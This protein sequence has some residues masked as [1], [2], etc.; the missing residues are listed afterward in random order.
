MNRKTDVIVIGTGLTGLTAALAASRFGASVRLIATG[1]G[2]LSISNGCIDLLGY[3]NGTLVEAPF[4]VMEN[5]PANHPYRLIGREA[6]GQAMDFLQVEL[7][8]ACPLNGAA[9]DEGRAVNTL[10]PTVAGTLK[11]SWLFPDEL[12]PR[13]LFSAKKVLVAGIK[14][15][16][17]CSPALVAAGLGRQSCLRGVDFQ[18]TT[19]PDPF[20]GVH[21]AVSP[22]DI[23]R[24]VSTDKGLGWLLTSLGRW[25]GK[26]DVILLPPVCGC[27]AGGTVIKHLRSELRCHVEEMLSVPPGVGGLRLRDAL[28]QALHE[29]QIDVI[30]N[31]PCVSA[32][33]FDGRCDSVTTAGPG[34]QMRH[35]AG[36]FIVATGGILGGG[37]TVTP[38][39]ARESIFGLPVAMPKDIL[40]RSGEKIFDAHPLSRMGVGVDA[41]LRALDA[42]GDVFCDNVF[43]AGRTLGGYDDTAEK[44]GNGVAVA[45]GWTA[46]RAACGFC[47]TGVSS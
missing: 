38:D 37:V 10:L 35:A 14:G 17:D 47:H 11:P 43:F 40:A 8:G 3:V 13:P 6:V 9:D 18:K 4:A 5:L 19:L 22:L 25:A 7:K 32:E 30:E 27:A 21:R 24:F 1:A 16:R 34:G 45:T 23:A 15:L 41:S 42:K 46:A 28:R 36:T 44:S 2:A 29:A 31:A 26:T 12:D 33:I 39:E 20:D